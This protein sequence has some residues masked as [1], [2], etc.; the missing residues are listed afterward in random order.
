MCDSM[1]YYG[2]QQFAPLM[3]EHF[4]YMVTR[5]RLPIQQNLVFLSGRLIETRQQKVKVRSQC[6][7]C[8][9]LLR[10]GS[11]NLTHRTSSLFGEQ[12]PLPQR[13]ILEVSEMAAHCDRRPGIQMSL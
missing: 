2:C 11:D 7:H 5:K 6:V 10:R 13:R 3:A 1:A 8:H 12:L 9:D 4:T